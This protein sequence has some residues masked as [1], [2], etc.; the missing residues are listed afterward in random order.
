[1]AEHHE[2]AIDAFAAAAKIRGALGVIVV[3]SV[4]RGTERPDSDVDVYEL[5]NDAQFATALAT[6]QLA[7]VETDAADWPGGY[8]D[9]KLISPELLR[10][11]VTEADDATRA[12][13]VGARVALDTTGSLD[14]RV[15]E[16]ANPPEQHFDE[17]TRSF[18][19]QFALHA[20]YFLTHG[21]A[22]SDPALTANAAVHA[23]FAAG[24]LALVAQRVLFRGPKYLTEQLHSAGRSDLATAIAELLGDPSEHRVEAVRAL[25]PVLA[26]DGGR[27]DDATLARFIIDNE[28]SWY[29]GR[30]V[31]EHR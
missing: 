20:D 25:V 17:L 2:R 3:G 16:I 27:I 19:A 1:M 9:I 29:T 30:P 14:A 26:A 28:W 18:A 31:P 22:H 5:V 15:A 23:A 24:R 12:S 8:I 10:R 7:R 6:E 11:A 4:A 13:L 21:R